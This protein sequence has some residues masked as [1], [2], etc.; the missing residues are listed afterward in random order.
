[1][2][3]LAFQTK[4]EFECCE[5]VLGYESYKEAQLYA[6]AYFPGKIDVNY[7][8]L[9][10]VK[11]RSGKFILPKITEYKK[12]MIVCMFFYWLSCSKSIGLFTG[13]HRT[14]TGQILKNWDPKWANVGM[15]LAILDV[16]ADYLEKEVP[17]R[18]VQLGKSKLLFVDGKDWLM[19][20][21]GNDNTISKLTFSSKNEDDAFRALTISTASGLVCETSALFGGRA[22]E[23]KIIEFLGSL[24]PESADV[25][26]WEDIATRD[27]WKPEDDVFWTALEDIVSAREYDN[28]LSQIDEGAPFAAAGVLD[29][30]VLI[31]AQPTGLAREGITGD[32]A[33]SDE[34]DSEVATGGSA[35][36]MFSLD[37]AFSSFKDMSQ[38]NQVDK[39]LKD[40]GS[41]KRAPILTPEI[42]GAQNSKA[43]RNDPNFSGKTKLR[44]LERHERLHRLYESGKLRKCLLSYFL[45]V[46]SKRRLQV[47]SWMGSE[48]AADVEK[49]TLD[50]IPKIP[51]RLA[52]LPADYGFC[53][54]KG[55]TGI[56]ALLPNVNLVVTP[57]AV[58][59]SKTHRL[60]AEMIASEIPVT[61]VRAPCETVFAR[62]QNENVLRERVKYRLIPYLPHG[63]ILATGETNLNKPLRRPGRQS[64]VDDDYWNDVVEY[65]TLERPAV[66]DLDVAQSARRVCATCGRSGI[67]LFCEKCKGWFHLE[68]DCH[69]FSSCCGTGTR[70]PYV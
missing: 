21:K 65:R 9:K 63:H 53:G 48:L 40:S 15:D 57:P 35:R 4:G 29:D 28:I 67:V 32:G 58:V 61:T 68:G 33:S 51:L 46:V 8:Q 38:S 18:N 34:S 64:I 60:S 1:M 14:C 47:L 39:Q 66:P 13:R 42:L 54:D 3:R 24:G 11:K 19:E 26:S 17:E 59:N 16:T 20:T 37:D 36:H 10:H 52:K 45:K 30:G 22:G 41:S 27:P 12:C 55:F 5:Y 69:D 7:D 43:I 49:P 50:Q 2:V 70:N 31:T 44:Q 56:E 23:R 25:A 6:D 62:V